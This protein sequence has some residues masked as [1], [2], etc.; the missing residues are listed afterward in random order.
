MGGAS[1][2]VKYKGGGI[3]LLLLLSL[4]ASQSFAQWDWTTQAQQSLGLSAASTQATSNIGQGK[5]NGVLSVD[6]DKTAAEFPDTT[7]LYWK[8]DCIGRSG[9]Y[10]EALDTMRKYCEFHPFATGS[11]GYVYNALGATTSYSIQIMYKSSPFNK[12]PVYQQYN[13]LVKMQ[14]VNNEERYQYAIFT[15]LA[16]CLENVGDYNGS[17]NIWWNFM[18]LHDLPKWEDS[19]IWGF[20]RSERSAQQD[21]PQD[22]T[23]FYLLT[24]PLHPL[25]GVSASV[26][27]EKIEMSLSPNPAKDE[28]LVTLML[29]STMQISIQVF[30][31]LSKEM[32]GISSGLREAGK[33]SLP[34]N[35][36]E[37]RAGTYYVRIQYPGGITTQQLV[38]NK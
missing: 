33:Q 1:N 7:R 29:P 6:C 16:N 22:T 24:F 13:W 25:A 10:Q 17:C 27:S 3:M 15:G 19:M 34:I 31:V 11:G 18:Q 21:I 20:I 35:T 4:C 23:P 2:Q 32:F 5:H 9:L 28:T 14:P 38:I 30:D 36:R 37:L 12:T 8:A 26:G